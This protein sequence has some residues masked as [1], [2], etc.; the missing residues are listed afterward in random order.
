M[1]EQPESQ[2]VS[3]LRRMRQ[4]DARAEADLLPVLYTQLRGIAQGLM[5]DQKAGHTLQATALVNDAWLKLFQIE[6]VEWENRRHFLRVAGRAMRSV[7]VDHAR[8]KATTKRGSGQRPITLDENLLSMAGSGSDIILAV[9]E[10]LERLLVMDERL[11]R[12]A[13]L[14]CFGGL[15]IEEI[16]ETLDLSVRTVERG[17]RSARAWLQ[18][19]LDRE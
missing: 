15:A 9:N 13:E 6:G 12:I 5:S 1:T 10:G 17:W 4:G 11:G 2:T 8:A 14:R 3:L 7:L 16:A 18:Q 19:E